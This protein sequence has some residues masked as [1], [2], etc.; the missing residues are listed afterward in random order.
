MFT[1]FQFLF[2]SFAEALGPLRH[3]YGRTVT[4]R[5]S[6]P[7]QPTVEDATVAMVRL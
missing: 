2:Q 7:T 4:Y 3:G 1:S 6:R 5:W